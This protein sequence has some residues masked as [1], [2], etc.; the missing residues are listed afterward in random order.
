M[1][2]CL[3]CFHPDNPFG[4]C[5]VYSPWTMI[6][7][8]PVLLIAFPIWIFILIMSECYKCIKQSSDWSDQHR[9]NYQPIKESPIW[10]SSTP[11]EGD[12]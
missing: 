3:D 4:C 2:Y 6:W 12:V 9:N 7:F 5:S 11:K 10:G 8:A 1:N